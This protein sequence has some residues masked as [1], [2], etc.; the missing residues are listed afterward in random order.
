MAL[1]FYNL[2]FIPLQFG[3]R[4]P[5]KGGVLALEVLT[6][7]FYLLEIALRL[8]TLTRLRKLRTTQLAFIRTSQDRRN[9]IR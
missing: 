3:Y 4:I 1:A 7:I 6:I 2:Y 5:F 9:L 8:F